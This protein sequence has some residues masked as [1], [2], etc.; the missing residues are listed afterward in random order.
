MPD[1]RKHSDAARHAIRAP[2]GSRDRDGLPAYRPGQ[3]GEPEIRAAPGHR[4]EVTGAARG[5]VRACRLPLSVAAAPDTGRPGMA[6]AAPASPG[7]RIRRRVA[8]PV[9]RPSG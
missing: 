7:Y 5:H 3:P 2:A 1:E 4:A 6:F 8:V 9:G